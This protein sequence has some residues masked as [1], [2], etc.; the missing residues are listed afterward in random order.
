MAD[1]TGVTIFEPVASD[2]QAVVSMF[3]A[4]ALDT[5]EITVSVRDSDGGSTTKTCTALAAD[6]AGFPTAAEAATKA[7]TELGF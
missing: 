5:I 2:V 7:A 4:G 1:K 6:F 3:V